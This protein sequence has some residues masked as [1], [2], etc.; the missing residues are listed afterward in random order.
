[1]E[2]GT[3]QCSPS[4]HGTSREDDVRVIHRATVLTP[5]HEADRGGGLGSCR[6]RVVVLRHVVHC[7]SRTSAELT[8]QP[9]LNP[10]SAMLDHTGS[11]GYAA[12]PSSNPSRLGGGGARLGGPG[13]GGN[14]GGFMSMT[15]LRGGDSR[16]PPSMTADLSRQ[17]LQVFLRLVLY[18]I[19]GCVHIV[20]SL[21]K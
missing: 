12:R 15:D 9:F 5:S 8:R 11:N 18:C 1:M 6:G 7:E 19:R 3:S 4:H 20:I 10:N 21:R 2:A 17:C 16:W 13:P 14:N